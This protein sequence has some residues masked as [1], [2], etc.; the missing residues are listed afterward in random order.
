MSQNQD[1]ELTVL[2]APSV[3]GDDRSV[4]PPGA[5]QPSSATD[6]GAEPVVGETV[7]KQRFVLETALGSGGMGTVYKARDLRRVEAQDRHP[8]VAIKLL[9]ADFKEHPEAFIALEREA[10]KSQALSHPNIVS[11][12][13]FDKDG[14]TPFIVMELLEG[15][16]LTELL[17]Q[18]PDG[19]PEHMAWP[20]I[21]GLISGLRH[22]HEAGV[23]H[24]DFK[25]GNVFVQPD[26]SSKI[27][28]FGIARAVRF[29]DEVGAADDTL[30]DPQRLAAL[31]PA[32]A[33]REM[34]NGDSAEPR[35]DL[36]SLGIVI[37]LIL[38]GHHPY[39]RMSAR[40]AAAEQ[41]R[42]DRPRRLSLRRWR[43][44]QSCLKF[45]RGDR[46]VSI[47]AVE[48]S[49]FEPPVWR[50]RTAVAA[51]IGIVL[52]LGLTM[53]RDDA[54]LE[55]VKE[56][57][58]QTA[59]QD[60]HLT[61]LE[62][63]AEA[64]PRT[65]GWFE[66]AAGELEALTAFPES[67]VALEAAR[68][69]LGD[70][71][72]AV[73]SAAPLPAALEL[74]AQG[75][76]VL[77][78]APLEAVMTSRLAAEI[79]TRLDAAQ[80]ADDWL[81]QVD[82]LLATARE[83]FPNSPRW[84]ELELETVEQWLAMTARALEQDDRLLTERWLA[85]LPSRSFLQEPVDDLRD[86][87]DD[88]R[89]AATQA[90]QLR[91]SEAALA[92][93]RRELARVLEDG[94]PSLDAKLL[95]QRTQALATRFGVAPSTGLRAVEQRLAA[96]VTALAASTPDRAF[97]L[98]E[99]ALRAFGGAA[100]LPAVAA[101]RLDPCG[102]AFLVGQ[103]ALGGR[104]GSCADS[105]PNDAT[106]ARLVV[107]PGGA[108]PDFALQ[109]T[110]VTEAAFARFC[111]AQSACELAPSELP[112]RGVPVVLA[113][114]Y[115]RWLSDQTGAVY[116]LPTLREW[117]LAAAEPIPA[118]RNCA[119]RR[120]GMVRGATPVPVA[121]GQS[122]KYGLLHIAGNVREWVVDETTGRRLAVGASFA[123]PI[124]NCSPATVAD[125]SVDGDAQTGFR[126]LR[127]VER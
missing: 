125:A 55:V 108:T 47:V 122:S 49:F 38:T 22:A 67:T 65:A 1:S 62:E 51:L 115:A 117:Q 61:R 91:R 111:S 76:P 80:P 85:E 3:T 70:R 99:D 66:R 127:E 75:R 8:F 26:H 50:S 121:A 33:S 16:E 2:R 84:A 35:D 124:S 101:V 36:Y 68:L 31:T 126:L 87:L 114:R 109:Q 34:L 102:P 82:A 4:L 90:E 44:L 118:D 9:N 45:N 58:R 41:L 94:C 59:V 77:P 21:R 81:A 98:R 10:S 105:L 27:L 52:T 56:E 46:P 78:V 113:E 73:A 30:F 13:D 20:I 40:D 43:A 106:S 97:S 48:R 39:G 37:Y 123:D 54:E 86:G 28:D 7:L 116:R 17:R 14:A 88:R 64:D 119:L 112:V 12:F 19:L 103:G 24:A 95:A 107:I 32:Y 60:V 63:L 5:A 96:C 89:R 92:G 25:P 100:A 69:K 6:L 83:T 79:Q 120:G 71:L 72:Y 42:P 104:R 53:L 18:F 57:A 74:L 93:Y 23:V 15:Q 29:S 11:I 110:E